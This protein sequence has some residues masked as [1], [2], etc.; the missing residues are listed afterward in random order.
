M[1]GERF[2]FFVVPFFFLL[3]SG[4]ASG[5]PKE[6]VSKVTYYGDFAALQKSPDQYI[7]EFVI[8][9]GRIVEIRNDPPGSSIIAV[10]FPLDRSHRPRVN[11]PSQGRFLVRSETFLDPAI[12]TPGTLVSVAGTI[13]G[14]DV[15]SVGEYPYVYPVVRLTEIWKWEAER[16]SSYP[17]FHFGIG[18]GTFF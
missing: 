16:D 15:R 6:V 3:L 5:V 10:Q 7:G 8:L 1:V 14:K 13:A 12:Y 11:E 2:R 4:C 18:V 9:G 17:R